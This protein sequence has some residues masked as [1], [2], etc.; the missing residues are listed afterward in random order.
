MS[1]SEIRAEITLALLAI[2]LSVLFLVES[3]KLKPGVFEPIGP[4]AVPMGVACMTIV[5]S[6]LVLLARWRTW[7]KQRAAAGGRNDSAAQPSQENWRLLWAV[8]ALTLVYGTLLQLGVVR[9]GY[10][11]AAYLLLAFL[12][13]A[14][15]TRRVLPWAVGLA[16]AFGIGLDFVFRYL[17]V[18]DLP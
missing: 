13:I 15:N 16:L 7:S 11:T 17:L 14:S 8:G 2:G 9:Y 10:V 5:L 3:A 6:L 4:G 1:A 18:A 12:L